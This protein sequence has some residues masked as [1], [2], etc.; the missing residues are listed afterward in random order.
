M[1]LLK[2]IVPVTIILFL[3]GCGGSSGEKDTMAETHVLK[4][5]FAPATYSS[6]LD[7]AK[8]SGELSEEDHGLV[9][10]FIRDHATII[11]KGHTL[12]SLLD[13][14]KGLDNMLNDEISVQVTKANITTDRKI[15]GFHLHVEA[16]NQSE[17]AVSS[18]RGYLQWLSLEGE[19][20]KNSPVFS[21]R[22]KLPPEGKLD[23]A[24]LQTAYYKPTGNELNDPKLKAWR[25]TLKLM[26][27]SAGNFDSTRFRFQ[28]TDLRLANGLSPERYWLKPPTE[29]EELKTAE[30][31]KVRPASLQSWPKKNKEWV[32]K[33][34]AGLG[35]HYLEV[36]P[37]LTNKGEGT[38]GEYLL[39][40]RINKV[41]K[42]FRTQAKVPSRR[43]NPT[44]MDGKLVHFEEV[45]FWKWPMELRIYESEI[46]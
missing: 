27:K 46:D 34:T 33:L 40:D 23:K 32:E 45:D 7:S 42:F 25:D 19:V 21:M 18:L 17:T 20:L 6:L 16:T 37:I 30:A 31:E 44:G 2:R 1:N 35:E 24:L 14:A 9:L 12:Q 41:E 13:G 4:E 22:G 8:T 36:T 3:I 29:R 10:G 38:H 5:K 15:Y 43:I 26:E 39:F 11:P 28:L